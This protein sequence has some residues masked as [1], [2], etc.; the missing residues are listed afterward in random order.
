MERRLAGRTAI[1]TGGSR[2]IGLAV[3][4]RLVADGAFVCVTGRDGEA[5]DAAVAT[6]GGPAQAL[7]VAG[8]ADDDAHQRETVARVL[9]AR[10][11]IDMLVNNVGM[12]P[13]VSSLVD[14]EA[15]AAR[16]SRAT[17]PPRPEAQ[18]PS[19]QAW[20]VHET[21]EPGHALR[22]E[23]TALPQPGPGQLLVEV[24]AVPGNFPDAMLCRGTYQIRPALPFTPG[25]EACGTVAALG[26]GVTKFR[27]G[28]RV[29]GLTDLPHGS[30]A[31]FTVLSQDRAFPAPEPL[32]DAE[33]AALTLGYQTGWFGLHRRANLRAGETLLVHAAAGGVGSAAVQ[34]G[35]AAGATVIAVV[36]GP[37]K[38]AAARDL[39]ADIV[40]DRTTE[41]FVDVVKSATAGRGADVVYDPVGGDA[42]TRST[43][44]VAFEGRVLLV[45]FAGGVIPQPHLNH[46]LIKNYSIVGLHWGLYHRHDPDAVHAAHKELTAL[47]EQGRIRPLISERL[48]FS[49]IPHGVDRVAAGDTIGRLAFLPPSGDLA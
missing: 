9:G 5:L 16:H 4:E 21:G 7:A 47:A 20:V 8:K 27:V 39:G 28:D 49:D 12:N 1:V 46:A 10:G 36:G 33:C 2:G 40:V 13:V 29:L 11:R 14:L 15:P 3:A 43:K 35:K 48:G 31:E 32:D 6:L 24:R 22:R 34:L 17:T 41:D 38:A 44:C 42:Y 23:T 37:A 19:M 26:E 30:F 45:G 25:V 18:M